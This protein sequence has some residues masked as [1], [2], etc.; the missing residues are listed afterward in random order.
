[1]LG[2]FYFVL[3]FTSNI[4]ASLENFALPSY[5]QTVSEGS[6][7]LIN[8]QLY[9]L[10]SDRVLNYQQALSLV[11]MESY[12]ST[13]ALQQVQASPLPVVQETNVY[14]ANGVRQLNS[15]PL[16]APVRQPRS[17]VRLKRKPLPK[18]QVSNSQS[19]TVNVPAASVISAHETPIT[20][21]CAAATVSSYV[22]PVVKVEESKL[23]E[24]NCQ[25]PFVGSLAR[26]HMETQDVSAPFNVPLFVK[27]IATIDEE[28]DAVV[29]AHSDLVVPADVAA[30]KKERKHTIH[31]PLLLAHLR[32]LGYL[33]E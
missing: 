19:V 28:K 4:I 32:E 13:F 26:W 12:D 31:S 9:V 11:V 16:S 29:A 25:F 15:L 14:S 17:R 18:V 24:Q 8:G 20:H 23:S 3:L 5:Q 7:F 33:S 10:L 1:M 6:L 30:Q 27:N 2:V 21:A 22:A